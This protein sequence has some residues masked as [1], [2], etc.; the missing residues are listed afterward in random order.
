MF[1]HDP[2][3]HELRT[4]YAA[5]AA[6]FS[7]QMILL[8]L[9]ATTVSLHFTTF[10]SREGASGRAGERYEGKFFTLLTGKNLICWWTK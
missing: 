3:Q 5:L 1:P 10:Q 8:S 4:S 2:E 9:R 6:L 7:D